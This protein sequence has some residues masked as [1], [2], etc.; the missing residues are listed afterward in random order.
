MQ[1][2]KGLGW[3]RRLQL[4]SSR[5]IL[6][7]QPVSPSLQCVCVGEVMGGQMNCLSP[8]KLRRGLFLKG[9]AAF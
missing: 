9:S 3:V 4:N 5:S 2:D 8:A 6:G 1:A 7:F